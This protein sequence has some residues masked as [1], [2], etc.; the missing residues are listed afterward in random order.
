M[1]FFTATTTVETNAVTTR[2]TTVQEVGKTTVK[3]STAASTKEI[4]T[5]TTVISAPKT[6]RKCSAHSGYSQS[7]CKQ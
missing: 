5:T 7:F 6:T 3:T 4:E 1:T 2:G